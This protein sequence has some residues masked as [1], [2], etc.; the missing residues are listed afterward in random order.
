MRL[1]LGATR[2]RIVRQLLIESVML[3]L[4]GG[5][6][7]LALATVGANGLLLFFVQP[8]DALTIS[9]WPDAR[10]LAINVLVSVA[11][12]VAF[13]LAPAFQGARPDVGPVLKAEGSRGAGRR[14]GPLAQ[15]ARRRSSRRVDA[16]DG[17]CRR[18]PQEPR[19]PAR[20]R[21]GIHDQSAALLQCLAGIVWIRASRD[22]GVR[23]NPAGE[24]QG[25]T[26]SRRSWI[27]VEP[28]C[29]RVDRGT[30]T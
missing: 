1:A 12:G 27:R 16:A 4:A 13:G 7:G 10:L 3:S 26:R 23:E 11:T 15:G 24:R 19:Q 5:A 29:S 28:L 8:D 21:S 20:D 14:E 30:A 22:Q 6:A 9:A 17:R 2:R 25:D 18:L